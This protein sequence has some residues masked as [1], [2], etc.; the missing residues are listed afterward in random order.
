MAKTLRFEIKDT[1]PGITP[2]DAAVLFDPFVQT[3]TGRQVQEGTGLGLAI[4]RKFV[5]LMGGDIRVRSEIGKGSEFVFDIEVHPVDAGSIESP[6][7]SREVIGIGPGQVRHKILI[8][9]DNPDSRKLLCYIHEPFGFDLRVAENGREAVE[10]WREWKPGLIWMDMRM[11]VMD[12]CEAVKRSRN[13]ELQITNKEKG[14]AVNPE[15]CNS[16]FVIRNC[17][18]IAQTAFS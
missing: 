11:P 5:Q 3:E 13:Y 1:G 2:E 10:T 16:Q 14:K 7:V 9:D 12:G 15:I 8:V 18:I 17:K 4:S 6:T